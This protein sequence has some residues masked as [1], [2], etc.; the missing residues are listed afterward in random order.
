MVTAK[1]RE[2]T[3]G[4]SLVRRKG[5]N[6]PSTKPPVEADS[7]DSLHFCSGRGNFDGTELHAFAISQPFK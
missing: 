4:L 5:Q 7:G 1:K 6:R 2:R 3:F